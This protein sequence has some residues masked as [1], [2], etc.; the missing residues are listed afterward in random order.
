MEEYSTTHVGLDVHKDTTAIAVAGPSPE[1]QS[2][3]AP[4]SYLVPGGK[5]GRGRYPLLGGAG[6]GGGFTAFGGFGETPC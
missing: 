1:G 5:P 6:G 4:D 3:R 2:A